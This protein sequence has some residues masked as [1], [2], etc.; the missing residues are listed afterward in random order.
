MISIT[1]MIIKYLYYNIDFAQTLVSL[2]LKREC[3]CALQ[4]SN[5]L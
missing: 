5:I 2:K 4:N 3:N 1:K